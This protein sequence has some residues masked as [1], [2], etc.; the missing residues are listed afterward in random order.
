MTT[1]N[2]VKM[3]AVTTYIAIA[4]WKRLHPLEKFSHE[5]LGD[6][7]GEPESQDQLDA[8]KEEQYQNESV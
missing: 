8:E 6:G 2:G 1:G 4:L 3:T 5:P 7:K